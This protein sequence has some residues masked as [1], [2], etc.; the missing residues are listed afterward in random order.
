MYE[1]T[2]IAET[3]KGRS[4]SVG[5]QLKDMLIELKLNKNT[6]SSMYS[7]SMPKCDS[8]ARIADYLDCS[9]DYLLGRTDI[10]VVVQGL[11]QKECLAMP[12]RP[13]G[14]MKELIDV[15][16][17]LDTVQQ[18]SLLTLAKFLAAGGAI[19][20]SEEEMLAEAK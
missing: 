16:S 8:L 14:Q 20:S 5:V 17:T 15:F 11:P 10:P 7:G 18:N 12:F 4:K 6:L 1:S 2:R 9:V 13:T 3:I 19:P